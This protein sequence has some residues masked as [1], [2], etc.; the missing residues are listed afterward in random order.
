MV[1]L[2]LNIITFGLS[3]LSTDSIIILIGITIIAL[4]IVDIVVRI[5]YNKNTPPPPLSGN[6]N[7]NLINNDLKTINKSSTSTITRSFEIPKQQIQGQ[8][9]LITHDRIRMLRDHL[10][11]QNNSNNLPPIEDETLYRFLVAR[12]GDLVLAADMLIKCQEVWRSNSRWT[13]T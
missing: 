10:Q 3:S 11:R 13:Q 1:A 5:S 7:N 9:T 8:G 12:K 4:L 2:I 6:N